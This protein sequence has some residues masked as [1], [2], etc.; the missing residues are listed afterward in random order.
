MQMIPGRLY[1]CI[2]GVETPIGLRNYVL[3]ANMSGPIGKEEIL[4]QIMPS[5]IF[6]LVSY[7]KDHGS[8]KLSCLKIIYRD[9]VGYIMAYSNQVTES[10]ELFEDHPTPYLGQLIKSVTEA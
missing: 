3:W 9:M 6:M 4:C 8:L 1:K 5:N 2:K 7:Q 10:F